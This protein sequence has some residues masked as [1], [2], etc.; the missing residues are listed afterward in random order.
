MEPCMRSDLVSFIVC[1]LDTFRLVFVI[2][3]APIIPIYNFTTLASMTRI[4][5]WG[6][7]H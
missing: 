3:T 5:T 7:T 4:E 6:S 1:I 2:Y